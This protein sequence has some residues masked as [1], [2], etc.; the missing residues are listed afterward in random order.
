MSM[1]LQVILLPETRKRPQYHQRWPI[2][3]RI[4]SGKRGSASERFQRQKEC[5]CIIDAT[6]DFCDLLSIY[7]GR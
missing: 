3:I 1:T 4:Y 2:R 7:R 5:I 6:K